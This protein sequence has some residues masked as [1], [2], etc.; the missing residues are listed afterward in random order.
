MTDVLHP[1]WNLVI[2]D[3]YEIT[4]PCFYGL[5]LMKTKISL[6]IFSILFKHD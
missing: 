3:N 6:Q 2:L 5:F 1:F 4:K